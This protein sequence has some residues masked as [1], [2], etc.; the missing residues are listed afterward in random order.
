M[1]TYQRNTNRIPKAAPG[2]AAD[3]YPIVPMMD[4]KLIIYGNGLIFGGTADPGPFASMQ[5]GG[6]VA[7]PGG[8]R[9]PNQQNNSLTGIPSSPMNNLVPHQRMQQQ[10]QRPWQQQQQQ[11]RQQPPIQS[12]GI[13]TNQRIGMNQQQSQARLLPQQQLHQPMPMSVSMPPQQQQPAPQSQAYNYWPF[14]GIAQPN[15]NM[16]YGYN[17]A[18]AWPGYTVLNPINP[19]WTYSF[20]MD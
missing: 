12:H 13:R 5:Q 4:D 18:H 10:Q 14:G 1:T 17:Q 3:T 7:R 8:R 2:Y 15:N 9:L 16:G 19:N 20:G 11:P 6:A